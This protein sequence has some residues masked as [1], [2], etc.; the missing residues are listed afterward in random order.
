LVI[1]TDPSSS[2][3][4][5]FGSNWIVLRTCSF[6]ATRRLSVLVLFAVDGGAKLCKLW[7]EADDGDGDEYPWD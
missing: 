4:L 5:I 2:P 3:D 7:G 1:H 6:M